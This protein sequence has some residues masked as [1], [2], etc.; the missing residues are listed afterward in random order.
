MT[1]RSRGDPR[2]FHVASLLAVV[3]LV[4]AL[5]ACS[6]DEARTR[7]DLRPDRAVS[8]LQPVVLPDLASLAPSVQK[9]IRD[10]YATL[11]TVLSDA[12]AS[13]T[14]QA[15]AYGGL[16]RL[17]LAAKFGDEATSCYLHAEAL[18]PGDMRWPYFLGHAYRM[19]GDRHLAETAFDR[20][21]KLRPSEL[22]PLVWLGHTYLEDDQP[23]AAQATFARAL[24]LQPDSAAV[25]FGAGRAALAR[26]AYPD[27]VRFLER[28]LTIDA[29][30]SAVHYPLAMAYRA[31][32]DTAKAEAHLR[33]RGEVWPSLPDRLMREDDDVLESPI[34]YE[35]RGVQALRNQDLP[36]AAAAFRKGLE[37]DPNDVTLRYWLGTTRYASGDVKG[38]ETEFLN[39]VHQSPDHAKAHFSLGAIYAATGRSAAAVEQYSAA[40]KFDPTMIDGR[41]RL[42]QT[43][44]TAGQLRESAAQYQTIVQMNPTLADAWIGGAQVLIALKQYDDV[45]KWLDDARRLHP[46]RRELDALQQRVDGRN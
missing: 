46:G 4:A 7:T 36:G 24:S 17:L 31:V 39:V 25:L 19:K 3:V 9:Q 21:T 15:S 11:A 27:A 22:A 38:A 30:A 28:S 8:T 12:R 32:G 35:H 37:L 26:G 18:E 45:R 13:R 5:P 42:A 33:Q 43:L 6:R 23:D 16:A 14:D 29:G 1:A 34:S 41:L 2:H 20:A 40:I 44:A 10:Q